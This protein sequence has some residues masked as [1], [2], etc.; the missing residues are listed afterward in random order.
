[1]RGF[2]SFSGGNLSLHLKLEK[3]NQISACKYYPRYRGDC[4]GLDLAS[5]DRTREMRVQRDEILILV[6]SI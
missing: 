5:R 1:M 6:L 4:A 2:V 3:E